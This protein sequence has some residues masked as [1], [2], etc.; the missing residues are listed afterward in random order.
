MKTKTALL[1]LSVFCYGISFS[2]TTE[3]VVVNFKSDSYELESSQHEKLKSIL[4]KQRTDKVIAVSIKGHT[5]N[6]G[7]D[8]YNKKLSGNRANAVS[9]FLVGNGI[10]Q[11]KISIGFFG[12]TIPVEG[13]VDEEGKAY[14]RRVEV[15]FTLKQEAEKSVTVINPPL[16]GL[17]KQMQYFTV[18]TAIP[19][20]L[21]T[22]SGAQVRIPANAFTDEKGRPIKGE[23]Q[24]AYRDYYKPLEVLLSGIPMKYDSA[25]SSY[26]FE[27]DGMFEMEALQ[28]GKKLEVKEGK[29]I[30]VDVLAT[31]GST[32]FNLYTLE[33]NGAWQNIG[34]PGPV[35]QFTPALSDAWSI[36]LRGKDFNFPDTTPFLNR[37]ADNNYH[38]LT[39]KDRKEFRHYSTEGKE[40][41]LKKVSRKSGDKKDL[42][43]FYIDVYTSDKIHKDMR[44]L[45]N[46][47]WV[48]DGTYN[49]KDFAANLLTNNF[50]NK[51]FFNNAR[52][53]KN[54]AEDGYLM[55]LKGNNGIITV[56]VH[57][58]GHWDKKASSTLAQFR[59]RA[60]LQS[61]EK[62]RT[63]EV[64]KNYRK[65]LAR[66]ER[67]FNKEMNKQKGKALK[68]WNDYVQQVENTKSEAE[69][70]MTN[71]EWLSYVD[72]VQQSRITLENRIM[73]SGTEDIVFR[74]VSVSGMGI[75]NCDR[76]GKLA[77]PVPII[78]DCRDKEN[79]SLPVVRAYVID[80]KLNG[81]MS[82]YD[83]RIT[84]DPR[85]TKA[86]ILI[87]EEGKLAYANDTM[88]EDVDFKR[89]E[90]TPITLE[91]LQ[92]QP[93]SEAEFA[94]LIGLAGK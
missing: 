60:K 47:T 11:E 86:I 87:D 13:N 1:V 45:K 55:E 30:D 38:Y 65:A 69:K 46:E 24:L 82:F 43:K 17:E 20:T 90:R 83:N 66:E 51:R 2:Q 40:F 58:Y 16:P 41:R 31:P 56:P 70:K 5:D 63:D 50:E 8:E 53:V 23:I 72:K 22:A 36:Y 10:V 88:L 21:T 4:S 84:L 85:T 54:E 62:R 3:K 68:V 25:G 57:L 48:Y 80:K 52:L 93:K 79:N 33:D 35:T 73:A 32:G 27:T 28:N 18:N 75:Y 59:Y 92:Q 42:V 94:S 74:T 37:F 67:L 34:Q 39:R 15:F 76:I 12:E 64:Y 19:C 29:T 78:A 26:H 61:I 77:N 14:N 71:E 81:S 9:E 91:K 44:F 6:V 49:K 7:S 89:N